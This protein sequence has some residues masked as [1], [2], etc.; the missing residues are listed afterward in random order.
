MSIK[1]NGATSGS[2]EL[3]VPDAVTGGDVT[4]TLPPNDGSA[5]QVLSTNGAGAL[6][7]VNSVEFD[8]WY[9][10]ADETTTDVTMTNWSRYNQEA[11]ASPIGTGMTESSGIFT[12]PNTGKWLVVSAPH[13]NIDD[14]DSTVVT[15]E[16]T[17]NN[18]SYNEVARAADGNNGTGLRS[19]GST[20]FAFVDVTDTANVKVRFR[21]LSL[22]GSSSVMGHASFVE[23]AFLFIRLGDT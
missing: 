17:T 2:V 10:T 3:G 23:S 1:L 16:V 8:Y 21:P 9:L 12:F 5:G 15:T 7:F 22:S 18:S 13:F 11:A 6:S 19:G 4:L 20:A 14:S